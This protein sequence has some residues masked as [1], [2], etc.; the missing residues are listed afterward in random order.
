[1]ARRDAEATLLQAEEQR[2]AALEAAARAKEEG[3]AMNA[4][5][6]REIASLR[7]QLGEAEEMRAKSEAALTIVHARAQEAV[8][9][10]SPKPHPVAPPLH[11]LMAAGAVAS[12]PAAAAPPPALPGTAPAPAPPSAPM[13]APAASPASAAASGGWGQFPLNDADKPAGLPAPRGGRPDD[14]RRIRGIGPK[15]EGVLNSLG[16]YHYEQIAS[17]T[18]GNVAW[19]DAYLKFHGRIAREDWVGQA[20]ALAFSRAQPHSGNSVVPDD[21]SA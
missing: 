11:P 4:L 6:A 18:S 7:A 14:L 15:N 20:K 9:A 8:R 19:L 2:E 3:R 1:M 13:S 10:A 21:A 17:L 16:I 12:P 5:S